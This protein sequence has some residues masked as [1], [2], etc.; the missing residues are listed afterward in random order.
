M[1]ITSRPFHQPADLQTVLTLARQSVTAE[2]LF[3]IP[4]YSELASWLAPVDAGAA[5]SHEGQRHLL[6]QQT[7]M[8]WETDAGEAV[9][10]AV[11]PGTTSLGFGILPHWRTDAVLRD[12]LTWGFTRL[13]DEGRFP[14]L[15]T[16][17]HEDDHALQFALSQEGFQAQPYQDV[18]LTCPLDLP[19]SAPALPD[20]FSL[21]EGVTISEH[22]AYQGLHRVI[23]ANGMGMDEHLSSTYQPELDLIAIAPDGTWAAFCF[24]TMDQVADTQAI[25]RL[26]DVGVLG[27]HPAFRRQG[28]GRALLLHVMQRAQQQGAQRM[29]LETENGSSPAMQL[30]RSVGFQPGSPWRWWRK[31]V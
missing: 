19:I 6:T 2:T 5:A 8:L 7:T 18:Y 14:F 10:Y 13:R 1:T 17:C 24:C 29:A 3:D 25:E 27:V 4:R 20:G 21:K 28:L 15:M 30:Y 31:T 12:I 22:G 26:G 23:F 11:I 16:R 9:A